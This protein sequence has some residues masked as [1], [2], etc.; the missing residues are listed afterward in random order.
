MKAYQLLPRLLHLTLFGQ[1]EDGEL[2][3]IGTD[4]QWKKVELAEQS[5][6]RHE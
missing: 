3:W 6:E 5:F 4:I 2:E 1:N